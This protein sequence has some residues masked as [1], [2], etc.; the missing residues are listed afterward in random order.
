MEQIKE[1]STSSDQSSRDYIT[2]P[3]SQQILKKCSM[4]LKE[5]YRHVSKLITKEK[6]K[7]LPNETVLLRH[8]QYRLNRLIGRGSFGKVFEGI[9]RERG[10]KVAIKV[11]N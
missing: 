1:N 4:G 5:I 11:I 10:I 3:N 2:S 7:S 8:G 6:L 9:D